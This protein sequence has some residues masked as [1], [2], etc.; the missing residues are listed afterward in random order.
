MVDHRGVSPLFMAIF[1]QDYALCRRLIKAGAD[2]NHK[3][4][5]G[6]SMLQFAKVSSTKAVMDLLIANGAKL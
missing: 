2:V 3:L 1:S 4:P 5:S 6:V